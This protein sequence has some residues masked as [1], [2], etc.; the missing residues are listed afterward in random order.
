[1]EWLSPITA[2]WAAAV[3]VPLLVLLY[4]LKLKRREQLISSTLLW[5]RAVQDLQVNAPFQKI[6]RNIL[7]LLQLLTLAAILLALAGPVIRQMS[8]GARRYVLLIDRSASMG[9][10]DVNPSRL[11]EAKRQAVAFVESLP[12]P[13]LF[14]LAQQAPQ[15]M[16]V[17][18]D[19]TASVICNFTSDQTQLIQAIESISQGDGVSLIG[20]ALTA[21]RAFAHPV[22]A[23]NNNRSAEEP[24]KILLF[25]DGR[26]DDLQQ[27]AIVADEV[28][29]HRIGQSGENLAIVA[30]QARREFE[31]PRRINV[32]LTLANY[33]Q[34]ESVCDVELAVNDTIVSIRPVRLMPFEVAVQGKQSQSGKVSLEFALNSEE[35]CVIRARIIKEDVL[36]A[37]NTVYAVVEARASLS[38]LLVTEGNSVL[39][40]VIKA[41]GIEKLDVLSP[42]EFETAAAGLFTA[43]QPYDVIV[44]DNVIA[45]KCP[46]GRYLVFGRP[47]AGID[48]TIKGQ[49]ENQFIADWRTRHPALQYV[50]LNS[51]F[52][53]KAYDLELPRD[54]EALAEFS[55]GPAIAVVRRQGSVFLLAGFDVMA[56]NWPFEPGF[57]LFCYNAMT[58]L[59]AQGTSSQETVLHPGDP[60]VV[61]SLPAQ[62]EATIEGP[63]MEP[64]KLKVSQTGMLR[65]PSV[66]KAG[67]YKMEITGRTSQY[68]AVSMADENES[69]I[70]P[71]QSLDF[72]GRQV[73]A[74]SKPV[75]RANL[76]LWP[77]LT[78][79]ALGLGLLEWWVYTGKL[80]L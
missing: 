71:A 49:F 4:F 76:P 18:F 25:S 48:V 55:R 65:L 59:S 57:V 46:R 2:I 27:Q 5:K 73:Q 8:A 58:Y 33:G 10:V 80:R 19:K 16:A 41:C 42:S 26:I 39:R 56:T 44:L 21:A 31:D 36:A 15:V 75:L 60:I 54:A 62:T 1:M 28:V 63:G 47:P 11:D 45:P 20:Q 38:A 52:A 74:E 17:A 7:L 14:S 77:Y 69:R 24:A 70:E 66:E 53:A 35:T 72:A 79:L 13:G 29:Y 9:A 37:D 22:E 30:V 78:F 43:Q 61:E 68:F 34:A 23:D 6:R 67:L 50:N 12:K 3:S 40:S 51:L 64:F 32:F